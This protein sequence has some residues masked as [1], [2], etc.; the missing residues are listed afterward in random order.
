M[1]CEGNGRMGAGRPCNPGDAGR[2]GDD[3][4]VKGSP[5]TL[6]GRGNGHGGRRGRH[7]GREG[8]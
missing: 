2:I 6:R 8:A 4:R 7:A 3:Y 5:R 1:G